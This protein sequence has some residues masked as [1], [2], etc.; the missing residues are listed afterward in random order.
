MWAHVPPHDD[1]TNATHGSPDHSA[2]LLASVG[3]ASLFPKDDHLE[4]MATPNPLRQRVVTR[5]GI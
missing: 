4:C 1:T 2:T 3:K 5:A